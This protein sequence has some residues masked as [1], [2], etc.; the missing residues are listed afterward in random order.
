MTGPIESSGRAR[1]S[2][3]FEL[4]LEA[5]PDGYREGA[6]NGRTWGATINRSTDLK[7]IWL[8]ARELGGSDFVSCNLYRLEEGGSL[9]KPCEMDSEK[10]VAFVLGFKVTADPQD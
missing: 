1:L 4:A 6:F 8:Y 10:V 3:E 9:L 7:R 5:L 2:A